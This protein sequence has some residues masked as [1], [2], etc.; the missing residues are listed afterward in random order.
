MRCFFSECCCWFLHIVLSTRILLQELWRSQISRVLKQDFDYLSMAVGRS[1]VH[2]T[3]LSSTPSK[4]LPNSSFSLFM[5]R[6]SLPLG[7]RSF[8]L[9]NIKKGI[10]DDF[11]PKDEDKIAAG[12]VLDSPKCEDKKYDPIFKQSY[13]IKSIGSL[14][15][16]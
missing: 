13:L 9:H 4:G 16:E 8:L 3:D 12:E 2:N 11:P 14:R 10:F 15:Q 7:F 6:I 1:A 5:F